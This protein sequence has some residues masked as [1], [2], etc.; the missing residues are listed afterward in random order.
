[1]SLR[2]LAECIGCSASA[3]SQIENATAW[4]SVGLL[5]RIAHHFDCSFDSL[6]GRPEDSEPPE[7]TGRGSLSIDSVTLTSTV[8]E[9]GQRV[10]AVPAGPGVAFVFV[11][12]GALTLQ[13]GAQTVVL[14]QGSTMRFE[15]GA[16]AGGRNSTDRPTRTLWGHVAAG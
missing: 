12:E 16:R 2:Q 4:P 5:I 3:L 9:P 15:P 13:L 7:P 8:L 6:L 11:A 14:D 10:A 1:M